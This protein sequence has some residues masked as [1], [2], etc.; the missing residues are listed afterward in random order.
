MRTCVIVNPRSQGGQTERRW[1]AL[2]DI[3]RQNFGPFEY[4]FTQGPGDGAR[5]AR[6]ALRGGFELIVAMGGDG[7]IS[8]V[9]DGF[10]DASRNVNDEA[11]LGILPAGTGGDFRRTLGL[12]KHLPEAA[13]ALRGRKYKHI[14]LGRLDFVSHDGKQGHRHFI[15][16]ASFGISGIVDELVN[17][18]SKRLGGRVS[19]LLATVKAQARFRNQR[20]WLRLDDSPKRER[21][22]HNV[23]VANGRYFGGGMMVAPEAKLDDGLFDVV[24]LGDLSRFELLM[25]GRHL[26]RGT[27]I[28]LPKVHSVRARILEAGPVDPGERVLL[29]VDGETPG[30]LPARFELLPRAIRLK[31]PEV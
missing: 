31:L 21:T 19:F 4:R 17:E 14:D 7:T 23:A 28:T 12:P 9:A 20:V 26:Y 5:V 6:E 16:I 27:H 2:A 13:S 22:I 8:E 1:G 25:G 18:G 10:I 3:I 30:R 11:V 24:E 15:N 29:D